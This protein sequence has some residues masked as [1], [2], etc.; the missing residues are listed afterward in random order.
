MRAA[1]AAL[2]AVLALAGVAWADAFYP[3][4]RV[5]CDTKAGT[6]KLTNAGA[7][8]EAGIRKTD[9]KRGVYVPSRESPNTEIRCDSPKTKFV[10]SMKPVLDRNDKGDSARITVTRNGKTV[11]EETLLDD[12][13][14]ALHSSSFVKTV[15]IGATGDAKV[16]HSCQAQVPLAITC[17]AG[18]PA[19]ASPPKK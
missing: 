3:A 16:E 11:L 18:S 9:A 8:N 7:Y 1:V 12:D 10:V 15:S 19:K 14:T 17:R 13:R 6:L 5:Q 2:I 4:L